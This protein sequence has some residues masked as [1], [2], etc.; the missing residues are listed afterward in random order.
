MNSIDSKVAS[1][2]RESTEV[3]DLCDAS[4][5]SSNLDD[6]HY[7]RKPKHA[8]PKS[9]SSNK[10]GNHDK[11]P[12]HARGKTANTSD[13]KSNR[14][15]VKRSSITRKKKRSGSRTAAKESS[16]SKR[17]SASKTSSASK[18]HKTSSKMYIPTK[19]DPVKVPKMLI[20]RIFVHKQSFEQI[21]ILSSSE[22]EPQQDAS[23]K[24]GKICNSCL[25]TPNE[26]VLA[27]N[28]LLVL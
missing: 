7:D 20:Q 4:D 24:R 6:T 28:I 13:R 26:F 16:A 12:T 23:A 8:R 22:E 11:K 3:V 27:L 2:K 10:V 9:A 19:S 14:M 21:E 17:S 18:H 15:D 25:G 5:G 1:S